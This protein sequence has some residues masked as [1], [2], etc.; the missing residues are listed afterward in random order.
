MM[1]NGRVR[2]PGFPC[3]AGMHYWNKENTLTF[4][5]AP[6]TVHLGGIGSGLHRA[7]FG[8]SPLLSSGLQSG[9]SGVG[10]RA[11]AAGLAVAS[12]LQTDWGCTSPRAARGGRVA[13][14]AVS[15]AANQC[16]AAPELPA[17]TGMRA[18]LRRE[19]VGLVA[20]GAALETVK[21]DRTGRV[22]SRTGYGRFGGSR[23]GKGPRAG[24]E[25]RTGCSWELLTDGVHIL[26]IS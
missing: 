9:H 3:A 20:Q 14:A 2:V 21:P 26:E 17:R 6:H 5:V 15:A 4:P 1:H 7:G 22:Q 25:Y 13:G 23:G 24:R 12:R 19:N 8:S 18:P 16:G 11:A 10:A